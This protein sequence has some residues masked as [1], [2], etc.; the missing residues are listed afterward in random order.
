MLEIEVREKP[1]VQT[2]KLTIARE[3]FHF[4]FVLFDEI[5]RFRSI[6]KKSENALCQYVKK[7]VLFLYAIGGW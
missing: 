6:Q 5:S 7:M 1:T 3:H 4:L 2:R